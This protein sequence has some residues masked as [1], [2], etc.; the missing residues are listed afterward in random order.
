M[1]YRRLS[2]YINGD[3]HKAINVKVLLRMKQTMCD[4]A[5]KMKWIAN[6]ARKGSREEEKIYKKEVTFM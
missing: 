5:E 2:V 3:L 4:E 6:K 1:S